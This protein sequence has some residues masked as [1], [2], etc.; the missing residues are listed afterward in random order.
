MLQK[1]M[2][3]KFKEL[4]HLS[5]TQASQK[6]G[7]CYQTVAN[8]NYNLSPNK[9]EVRKKLKEYHRFFIHVKNLFDPQV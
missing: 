8:S 4:F 5:I 1:D 7:V 3:R 2:I 6:L 9:Y